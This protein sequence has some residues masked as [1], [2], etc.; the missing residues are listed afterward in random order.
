MKYYDAKLIKGFIEKNKDDIDCVSCGMK[1]DWSWTAV[2][3]FKNGEILFDL[4]T[5]TIILAGIDG[6]YWATPVM[7]VV[8]KNGE[9]HII[10]CYFEDSKTVDDFEI[11]EMKSFTIMTGGMDDVIE[12]I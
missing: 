1:E 6:S 3:V 9:T 4:G 2:E 5:K 12:K 10:P 7:E 11:E 8:Y